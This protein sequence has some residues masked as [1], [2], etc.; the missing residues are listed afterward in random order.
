MAA[1]KPNATPLDG[2]AAHVVSGHQGILAAIAA[3]AAEHAAER[4]QAA[5]ARETGVTPGLIQA[6][7]LEVPS[8]DPA[9]L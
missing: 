4:A 7:A 6:P 1:V 9:A 8:G 5:L 3:H 2:Q